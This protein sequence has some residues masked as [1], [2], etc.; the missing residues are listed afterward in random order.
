MLG[1]WSFPLNENLDLFPVV[2]CFLILTMNLALGTSLW[3]FF[4]DT[5]VI[6]SRVLSSSSVSSF[7]P[8]N[9]TCMIM[10]NEKPI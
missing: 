9:F 4:I 10:R 6:L 2:L 1:F 7:K 3:T 8:M 5:F